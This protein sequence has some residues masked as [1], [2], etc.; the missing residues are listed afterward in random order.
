M[1]DNNKHDNE[2]LEDI[3]VFE[4]KILSGISEILGKDVPNHIKID[5]I[6]NRIDRVKPYMDDTYKHYALIDGKI[7]KEVFYDNEIMKLKSSVNLQ[8][9]V[10]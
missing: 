10:V 1:E 4:K 5:M 9:V 2:I 8:P 7:A 6:R 3:S